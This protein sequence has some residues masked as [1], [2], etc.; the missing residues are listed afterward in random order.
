MPKWKAMAGSAVFLVLAPG[1]V[2]GLLP[3]LLT[4]WESLPA[5]L[6]LRIAGAVLAIAGLGFLL[7]AFW[8][9]AVEGLGTPAPAAP[10]ERLVTGGVYR[11]VRNPMYLAVLA[12]IIGQALLLGQLLLAPYAIAVAAMFFAFA[13][14]YEEPTLIREFGGDYENYRKAVPG[15][16]PRWTPWSG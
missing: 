3:W 10:T 4:K 1:I 11:H 12:M 9:F 6:L 15:W 2:A 8:R 16:I 7:H 13:R 14:V 5:P